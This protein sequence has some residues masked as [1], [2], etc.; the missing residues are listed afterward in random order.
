MI[1]TTITPSRGI[2]QSLSRRFV[3]KAWVH[4]KQ[5]NNREQLQCWE[6]L[7]SGV[8][9]DEC[10]RSNKQLLCG[11]LNRGS[12]SRDSYGKLVLAQKM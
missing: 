6:A 9:C 8:A 4:K 11:V 7:L 2:R 10:L 5:E 1:T 12:Q 3:S